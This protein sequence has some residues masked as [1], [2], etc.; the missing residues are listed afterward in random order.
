[1]KRHYKK[2]QLNKDKARTLNY[3]KNLKV[4]RDNMLK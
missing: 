1:M 4:L 3:E 2:E